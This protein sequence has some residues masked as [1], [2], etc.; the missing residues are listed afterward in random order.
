ILLFLLCFTF[1]MK[2][3]LFFLVLLLPLVGAQVDPKLVGSSVVSLSLIWD[4]GLGGQ[5]PN[6]ATFSSFSFQNTSRQLTEFSANAQFTQSMDNRGNKLLEFELDPARDQQRILLRSVVRVSEGEFE[7]VEEELSKFLEPTDIVRI[8]PPISA[9]AGELVGN[10]SNPLRRAAV[11]TSWVHNNV[12]YD[13]AYTDSITDSQTV[14]EQRRGVCNEYSHLLIAMLRSLGIPARFVAGYVYS[15][16]IWAPHAW[17]EVAINAKWYPFDATYNEGIVLDATHLKFANGIDQ[18]EVVERFSARGNVDLSRVSITRSE[19][20]SLL[21]YTPFTNGPV[22]E[23]FVP[24]GTVAANSIQNVTVSIQS[25]RSEVTAFPLSLDVPQE[26][27]ILSEKT[28]LLMLFPGEKRIV[29]WS[30]LVPPDLEPSYLYTYPVV[31]RS[32]GTRSQSALQAQLGQAQSIS[33]IQLREV[34]HSAEGL[35]FA[36]K[37][38][39]NSDVQ[40]AEANVEILG[41]LLQKNFS[42]APGQEIDLFFPVELNLSNSTRGTFSVFGNAS[43]SQVFLLRPPQNLEP[44][45]PAFNIQTKTFVEQEL[46]EQIL[47]REFVEQAIYAGV[48]LLILLLLLI[49]KFR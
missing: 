46:L 6:S 11:L 48:I 7:Q 3:L 17:V 12:V 9:K 45:R 25:T 43:F 33:A 26:L 40:E 15:G 36:V 22:I 47:P 19:D 21:S 49:I 27:E 38:A 39:G 23:F 24:N 37:N 18:N 41:F 32:L 34:R 13:L 28:F 16:E 10:E 2:R 14:F 29:S 30:V 1:F 31:V 42:L 20:V 5:S 44:A 8:T 35:V 4:I